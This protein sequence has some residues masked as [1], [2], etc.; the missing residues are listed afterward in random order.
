[1]EGL[2]C[3]RRDGKVHLLAMCEGNRCRSGRAGRRPGGGRAQVFVEDGDDW[4]RIASLRL[5]A[6]LPFTDFS[7]IS[8]SGQRVAVVSQESSALWVGR[9]SPSAWG[10]IDRG[11]VYLFPRSRR[12][13]IRYGTVE[14]VSWLDEQTLAVVSDRA[15]PSQPRRTRRTDQSI[16]IVALPPNGSGGLAT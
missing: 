13:R 10:V 14:G 5:P 8:V 1:M 12:G 15:K 6:S 4:A 11:V 16:H 3:L 2:T 7:S 9:L